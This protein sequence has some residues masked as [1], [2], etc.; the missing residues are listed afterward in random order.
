MKHILIIAL[1]LL[2][3][4]GCKK[5]QNQERKILFSTYQTFRESDS[6]FKA[7]TSNETLFI[8][9]GDRLTRH[10]EAAPNPDPLWDKNVSVTIVMVQEEDG[11]T[12]KKSETLYNESKLVHDINIVIP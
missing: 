1:C 7:V 9:K 6:T 10:V 5:K 12:I 11:G 2:V 4:G 8:K 3:A